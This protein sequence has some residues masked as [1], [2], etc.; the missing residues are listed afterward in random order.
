MVEFLQEN[1]VPVVMI[2]V[3]VWALRWGLRRSHRVRMARIQSRRTRNAALDAQYMEA[4]L[5]TSGAI[6]MNGKRYS[7][8]PVSSK[9]V[10]SAAGKE[11]KTA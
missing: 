2:L 7:V 11:Q 8:K 6:T 4:R 10:V 9:P 3:L 5:V 1:W